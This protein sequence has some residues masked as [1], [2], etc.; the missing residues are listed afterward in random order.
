MRNGM[1]LFAAAIVA[2]TVGLSSCSNDEEGVGG[3]DWKNG[4]T[5]DVTL[6]LS[7]KKVSKRITSDEANQ[8]LFK[9]SKT[10]GLCQWLVTSICSRFR[11][12]TLLLPMHLL[13]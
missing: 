9:K 11:W 12:E 8:T 1:Y 5:K 3:T 4:P 13:I 10:F 2:S 6:S 7:V